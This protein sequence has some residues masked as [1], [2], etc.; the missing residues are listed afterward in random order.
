VLVIVVA[1]D[2]SNQRA[3]QSGWKRHRSAHQSKH[4]RDELHL[5]AAR[6]TSL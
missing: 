3:A 5:P 4:K 6:D 2:A 1:R